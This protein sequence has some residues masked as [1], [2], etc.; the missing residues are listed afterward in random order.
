MSGFSLL[1]KDPAV[2]DQLCCHYSGFS[3]KRIGVEGLVMVD[4]LGEHSFLG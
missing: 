1:V 3:W 2:L 4:T